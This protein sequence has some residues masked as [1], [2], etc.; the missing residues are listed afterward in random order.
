M[1]EATANTELTELLEHEHLESFDLEAM[2][3]LVHRAITYGDSPRL[4]FTD[5]PLLWLHAKR[6]AAPR[7]L[8]AKDPAIIAERGVGLCSDSVIVLN[9]L[10]KRAGLPTRAVGLVGH[11][12]AEIQVD[13]RWRVADPSYGPVFDV[14]LAELTSSRT[15]LLDVYT[16]PAVKPMYLSTADNVVT[17]GVSLDNDLAAKQATLIHDA[18][19]WTS[20][21]LG[22]CSIGLLIAARLMKRRAR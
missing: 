6:L 14:S 9:T 1:S 11:V 3:A 21:L 8:A 22:A 12:V 20:L 13:G 17:T 5:N 15:E 19:L 2:N 7:L 18:D 10:A 16:N 4:G